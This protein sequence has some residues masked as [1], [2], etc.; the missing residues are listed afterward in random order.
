MDYF[1]GAAVFA[2]LG[3]WLFNVDKNVAFGG[4]FAVALAELFLDST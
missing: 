3:V 4:T 2:L 1:I